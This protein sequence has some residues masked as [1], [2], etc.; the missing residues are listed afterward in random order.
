M[1]GLVPAIHTLPASRSVW[2]AGTSPAMTEVHFRSGFL[3][4]FHLL[5]TSLATLFVAVGPVE[6]ASMFL[7]LTAGLNE[8][9]K[10]NIA[11]LSST[12]ALGVLL[13]FALGGIQ[14]LDL[15]GV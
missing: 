13:A 15:I 10:R 3:T 6:V 5:P 11:L 9:R 7:A 8:K 1:A 4:M 14:L 12:V 2:V